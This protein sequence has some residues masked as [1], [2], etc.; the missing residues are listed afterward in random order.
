[1]PWLAPL[2]YAARLTPAMPLRVAHAMERQR[3]AKSREPETCQQR[4]RAGLGVLVASVPLRGTGLGL[5]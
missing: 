1:M 5:R 4:G 2:L 3:Q